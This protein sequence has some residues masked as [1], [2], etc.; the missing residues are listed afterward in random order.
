MLTGPG[1]GRASDPD[2]PKE[3]MA[4]IRLFSQKVMNRSIFNASHMASD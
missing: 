4:I 1:A 2:H 3:K